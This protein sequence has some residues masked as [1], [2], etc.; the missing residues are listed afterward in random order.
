MSLVIS[1]TVLALAATLANLI[2]YQ[3]F[4][5]VSSSYFSMLLGCLIALF[6][7]FN[8]LVGA[9][10]PHLF[11]GLIVAPLLFFEGQSTRMNRVVR[12]WETIVGFTV[13]MVLLCAIAATA[14]ITWLVG[15][16]PLAVILG[17]LSTPTDATATESVTNGLLVPEK[18]EQLLKMESLFNDASGIILLNMG[19]FWYVRGHVSVGQTIGEFLYSAIGG[20]VVGLV[21]AAVTVW[22]NQLLIRQPVNFSNR[23]YN[24]T[25]VKIIYLLTPFLVYYLA[26]EVGVSGIIAV[27]CAG[28][29]HNAG[30]ERSR[31]TNPQVMYDTQAIVSVINDT[32]NGMVFVI[33]G[34]AL[35]RCAEARL[36]NPSW[37]WLWVGLALY[38]ANLV[39]RYC[40]IRLVHHKDNYHGWVFALGGIHGA[41]TFALAYTVANTAVAPADVQLVIMS[42]IVLIIASLLIPTIVFQLMLAKQ[43]HGW[44]RDQL[45][46]HIRQQ[47]VQKGIDR[48]QS[49]YLPAHLRR[50]VLFDLNAQMNDTSMREFTRQ[51]LI[52]VRQP[53]LTDEER[54]IFYQAYRLAFRAELDYLSEIEQQREEFR[55]AIVHLYREI[56]MAQMLVFDNNQ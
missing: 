21:I 20:I 9:F 17:A 36:H 28:L 1:F 47:T 40:Y 12:N 4:S 35:V 10:N 55:P 32:L 43:P 15:S 49:V 56:L 52:D 2:Q 39:V 44:Q 48:V 46:Q 16:L 13:V 22:F 29:V 41:V 3:F 11:M 24:N 34:V 45:I 33:F 8:H 42:I 18:E 27:V 19:L 51:W 37:E 7:I 26:E 30:A 5:K 54:I 14:S 6:P 50:L 38:G 25:P 31:L 53:D 23:D